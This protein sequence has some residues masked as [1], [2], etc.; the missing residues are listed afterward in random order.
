MQKGDLT[1]NNISY[2]DRD[3]LLKEERIDKIKK[4]KELLPNIINSDNILDIRAL[5]D[6][7]GTESTTSNN[8][9]YE[10]T[11]AG[12][13]FAKAKVDQKTNKELK[14]ELK[15]SKNFDTTENVIIRGDNIDVLKILKQ[16]YNEKIKMIYIDPPYNTGND[17]FVYNDDFKTKE[18]ELIEEL[19]LN[20]DTINYLTNI[21]GTNKHSAWLSFMY[22]RLVLARQLL[23][24]DGVIF[25]SIDD[26]E[27]ANLKLLCDEIFGEENFVNCVINQSAKS[28]FGSKASAK[29]KTIIKTKD[30][31][32][33]YL[34]NHNSNFV[35]KPLYTKSENPI[36]TS[37]DFIYENGIKMSVV[38]WFEKNYGTKFKKYDLSINKENIIKLLKIDNKFYKEV[39]NKLLDIQY[40][41]GG[42]YKQ[43]VP[44]DVDNILKSGNVCI[45]NNI[46]LIRENNGNGKINFCRSLRQSCNLS[47][48]HFQEFC[49]VDILGDIWDRLWKYK[50]RR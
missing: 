19:G 28:V 5:K 8:Q 11:F 3:N 45:F 6:F 1:A 34:K 9:G 40:R 32:L 38:E 24:K 15:Q 31:V 30:Y 37:H 22:P 36:F 25:I 14:V 49:K 16:N 44:I 29:E 23:A 13:G 2:I 48:D 26:N 21:Y 50:C 39:F 18:E 41:A 47:S 4:I 46:L 20:E 27:Q 10:L 7:L 35:F 12:K 43:F 33:C 42:E 17:G